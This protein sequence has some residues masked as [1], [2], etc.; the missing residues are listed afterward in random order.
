MKGNSM[1]SV[2]EISIIAILAIV[3]SIVG[4]RK[5]DRVLFVCSY[6]LI[7]PNTPCST[8]EK[9]VCALL[10]ALLV[11]ICALTVKFVISFL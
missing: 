9:A 2:T 10:G 4:W 5:A 7:F 6:D 3:G 11:A 1:F 8:G